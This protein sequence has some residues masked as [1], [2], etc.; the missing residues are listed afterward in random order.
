VSERPWQRLRLGT[1]LTVAGTEEVAMRRRHGDP[2]D[3]ER[4]A[5][6]LYL[7]D[8]LPRS[9]LE[10]AHIEALSE[11]TAEQ[12]G[13]VFDGLLP[14]LSGT[15]PPAPDPGPLAELLHSDA[16]RAAMLGTGPA[17]AIVRRVPWSRA[18]AAYFS[19]G[20]GSVSI[21]DQPPWLQDLVGHDGA[22]LDAATTPPKRI[23]VGHWVG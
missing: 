9:V 16:G 3:D 7:V 18:V 2:S 1:T 10:K 22:P 23:N 15:D 21:D 6:Y 12:R 20:V 5:R 19:V 13:E 14:G 8:V 4:R 11:L 17:A